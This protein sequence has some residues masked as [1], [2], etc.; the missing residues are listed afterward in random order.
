MASTKTTPITTETFTAED[1]G[2]MVESCNNPRSRASFAIELAILRKID[3]TN[4]L[5][6]LRAATAAVETL[7]ALGL[8]NVEG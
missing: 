3:G 5:D 7:T 6:A 1:H 4:N 8:L 2:T